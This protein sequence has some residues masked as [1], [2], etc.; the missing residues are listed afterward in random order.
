MSHRPVEFQTP[1]GPTDRHTVV[2]SPIGELL[3]LG[4]ATQLTGLQ[5]AE[6]DGHAPATHLPRDDAAF[7]RA[8]QQLAQYFAGERTAFDLPLAPTGPA[9]SLSV[10][11]AL[12][13]IECGETASYGEIA[14]RL[15]N[16]GASRAVGMANNH[17]PLPIVIPCHRVVGADGTMTGFG[18]GIDRK[19]ELLALEAPTLF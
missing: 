16:P 6:A 8:R 3:L 4:T 13:D 7:D 9:F 15:G 17:N 19:H 14:H 5:F 18:G 1:T 10:W 11:R 12:V 2:P